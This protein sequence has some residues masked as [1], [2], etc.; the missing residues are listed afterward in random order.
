MRIARLLVAVVVALAGIVPASHADAAAIVRMTRIFSTPDGSLQFV[1]LERVGAGP[2]PAWAS[3]ET[4]DA[5][6]RW[7]TTVP[8][9]L[10]THPDARA[11]YVLAFDATGTL[12]FDD[13]PPAPVAPDALVN[14]SFVVPGGGT[15]SLTGTG[16][17]DVWR[18][19]APPADGRSMLDRDAGAVA[20]QFDNGHATPVA[21]GSPFLDA[22]E[23]VHASGDYFLTARLDEILALDSHRIAGWTRTGASLPVL[24][25]PGLAEGSGATTPV[26]RLVL[27]GSGVSHFFSASPQEC[28]AA[29]AAGA[30]LESEAIFHA[31]LPDRATGA[32][33]RQSVDVVGDAN[34][35]SIPL[36]PVYRLWNG[37]LE[38]AHHRW[39][40]DRGVRDAMVAQGWIAEGYG[41]DAVAMCGG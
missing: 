36:A 10:D 25:R 37:G 26:C 1:Q 2:W 28:D 31:S 22:I 38:A 16:F 40:T 33:P 29:R 41:P 11:T 39:T 27:L 30:I 4:D 24:A 5:A 19:P 13:Y 3:L 18:Y 32:C 8:V 21:V 12:R 9:P 17:S 35:R 20:A 7:I 15:L 6:G 14:R 23:F 34:P